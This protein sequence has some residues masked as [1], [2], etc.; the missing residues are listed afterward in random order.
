M[1][2]GIYDADKARMYTNIGDRSTKPPH[3]F[4]AADAAFSAMVQNPP[5]VKAN[6]VCVISGESGAGKVG[7]TCHVLV[8]LSDLL[9]D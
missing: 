1:I 8:I 4:A 7:F 2:K 5:G 9:L 3:V 6:Q